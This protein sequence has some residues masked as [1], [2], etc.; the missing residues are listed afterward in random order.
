M[1]EELRIRNFAIIDT[2]EIGF[3]P[4]FNVI[5]GETGAGKSIIIDAVELLLGNRAD[6]GSV[7]AGAEKATVEGIF[8][9]SPEAQRAVL[10]I[11]MREELRS[12]EGDHFVTL[13]REVRNNGRSTARVNGISVTLEVLREVGEKLVDIHGQSEHLSLLQPRS[14]IDLLDRYS[15]L[16]EM[17]GALTI[18]VGKLNDVRREIRHLLED[19][20]EIKRR[21][22]RLRR[23]VEEIE[24]AKLRPGEDDELRAER[25]RL[26]NSEQLAKLSGQALR[27][28]SGD[29]RAGDELPAVDRLMQVAAALSKLFAIDPDLKE[30]YQMAEYLAS[31][32]QELAITL[33]GY[34]EEVEYNP[35]R[36]NEV[37]ERLELINGLRRRYGL[38][39]D[40]VLEH[41]E[42]AK[43]E[44][45][46]IE[47]SEERLVELRAIEDKLLYQIGE[48]SAGMSK[49]RAAAGRHLGERVV[50][51]LRDL[52]MERTKFEVQMLHEEV[53]DGCYVEV[54]GETKRYAFDETGIDRVEFMMSANPGEPLRPLA[55]VASGGETARIMLAMKRVLSQADHTPTLIFD[56]IDQGIGGRV[57]VVVGEKLWSLTN[58]HQ[59]LCVTHLAQMAGYAD[60]HFHVRKGVKNNR[61][62]TLVTALD[63]PDLRAQELAAMLGTPGDAG[64]V[65]AQEILNIAQTYKQQG[66]GT[67]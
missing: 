62:L 61:T 1:L 24:A 25:T 15:D 49:A 52:R 41:A 67:K 8:V 7:R 54:D 44:L 22:E 33:A 48:M 11:L 9:L 55:K 46:G 58:G 51:E 37:E 16:Y 43:A 36:L 27:L 53:P 2:L 45:N 63:T 50:G 56:E 28:L 59:V 42:K 40:L 17:R 66:V 6:P 23:D 34:V 3:A 5:T 26:S 64:M 12:E 65:S 20:A 21:A 38:T 13:S 39:I 19:E 30:E 18:A 57:G 4:G 32:A 47:N 14:H 10:P 29:E 31:Q 60:A 35:N